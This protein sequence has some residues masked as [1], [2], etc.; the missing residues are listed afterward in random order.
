MVQYAD[1]KIIVHIRERDL[2]I[3]HDWRVV[4]LLQEPDDSNTNKYWLKPVPGFHETNFP[5]IICN[6]WE[7][8]N[9]INV[10]DYSMDRLINA[11]SK[12]GLSQEGALFVETDFGF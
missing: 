3:I 7:H 11:S 5:F 1:N 8:F 6:G 12:T 4:K 10:R 9:I 2:L